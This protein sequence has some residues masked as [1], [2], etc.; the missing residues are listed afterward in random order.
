MSPAVFTLSALFLIYIIEVRALKSGTHSSIIRKNGECRRFIG[1][2][3]SRFD[4]TKHRSN[5]FIFEKL[6]E[7]IEPLEV[8]QRTDLSQTGSI[9]T[10]SR[11]MIEAT[12]A[13][14]D[15]ADFESLIESTQLACKTISNQLARSGIEFD[16]TTPEDSTL[17]KKDMYKMAS[18]ILKNSLRFT[19]KIGVAT[20]YG[21]DPVLIEES[22]NSKYVAVFDPLDGSTNID[23]GIVTGTIFSIFEEEE[24]CLNDFGEE[25]GEESKKS[26]IQNLK[27]KNLVAAGYCMYSS[28]TIL[29][30]SMGEGVY[31]F[32]LDPTIGDFVLT[33]PDV[34]IPIRGRTYSINEARS[35]WWPEGLSD[36]VDAIKSGEGETGLTYT[37]R[38]IGSM[39]GDIHRTLLGGG[40]FAYPGDKKG[41]PDGKLKLLHEVAAM[42]FLVEQA[43][44]KASTGSKAILKCRPTTLHD[45]VSTF[46]G[47][48][49]DIKEIE[50]ALRKGSA[51]VAAAKLNENE[52]KSDN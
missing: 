12:R 50:K 26:L 31:G 33:H 1:R 21:E 6:Y 14:P 29:M 25:V 4:N 37:A 10:L 18:T 28:A 52:N 45:H 5:R 20:S 3:T 39:V 40:V 32:T 41:A 46:L 27:L 24:A 16:L 8:S 49:D 2:D 13:N 51:K 47:S 30:I 38:Y 43:G 7:T 11:F 23:A 42:A 48:T 44:G 36:Y 17:E 19:G 15:H 9:M 35:P 34:K 22:W